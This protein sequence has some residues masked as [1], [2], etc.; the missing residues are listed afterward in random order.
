MKRKAVFLDGNNLFYRSFFAIRELTSSDGTPTNAIFGFLKTMIRIVNTEKPDYFAVCF[1]TKS[2]T[3]RS[4]I[5]PSYKANRP[6]TPDSLI[7]QTKLIREI[8]SRI[9]ISWFE[10][11]GY[12]A[13]DLLATFASKYSRGGNSVYVY[14]GDRDLLQVISDDIQVLSPVNRQREP[15]LFNSDEVYA[16]YGVYPHQI[17]D[18]KSLVGDTSDNIKG[19]PKIGPK[20]AAK[21]LQEYGSIEKILEDV[22]KTT[23]KAREFSDV[24]IRNQRIIKLDYDVQIQ[25]EYDSLAF[26][27]LDLNELLFVS[28]RYNLKSITRD[29]QENN[30]KKEAEMPNKENLSE[31]ESK[32][33]LWN[34]ENNEV[35]LSKIIASSEATIMLFKNTLAIVTADTVFRCELKD[36]NQPNWFLT[37]LKNIFSNEKIH[38]F[39][40][41]IKSILHYFSFKDTLLLKNSD[42]LQLAYFID[43]PNTKQYS[44]EN[45]CT[46][47]Q[48]NL[49]S[50]QE[51]CVSTCSKTLM[52]KLY[53]S[54]EIK[55][56]K[57]LEMPLLSVLYDMETAGVKI[58][59]DYLQNAEKE[60]KNRIAIVQENIYR[61]VG[62]EFNIASPK[63]LAFI[64][65]EKMHLPARKK[66]KTGYSTNV[67]VL[68]ELKPLSPVIEMVIEFRELSKMLNTYVVGL[69]KN[70]QKDDLIHT[71]Y[72]QAGPATGRISSVNP[73]LQNLPSDKVWG[74]Y[75]KKAFCIRND[76]NIFVSADYS[77]IDLRVLAHFSKDEKMCEAF[78]SDQD[79][80]DWTARKIFSI[81]KERQVIDSYRKI[82]KTVNFGVIYGMTPHGLSQ[83]LHIPMKEAKQF[84]DMY[85]RTFPGVKRFIERAVNDAKTTGYAITLLGRRRPIPELHSSNKNIV[86]LGERLAVNTVI[87]GTSADI[88]K[89]AMIDI[90]QSLFA[91]YDTKMILQIH[92]EIITE[93]P[94]EE[95]SEVKNIIEQKMIHAVPFS[96]PLKVS[97]HAG[98]TLAELK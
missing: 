11:N 75:I 12:E 69:Y 60:L 10:L 54:D 86:S 89:K 42:D 1:D 6:P 66:T 71:T 78:C 68:E 72:L 39:L 79:I 24:L 20:T 34:E 65:F 21:L 48:T 17:V 57:D 64:L 61:E 62:Q 87:Q 28:R 23:E 90:N 76:N 19:V 18:F 3:Y 2:K 59:K 50:S 27:E 41:D 13:D 45:F 58:S 94:E 92:D 74:N 9:N 35:I 77:Q 47:Y 43:K 8:L 5:L 97:F 52:D 16:K 46:E 70:I 88:I 98:I 96:V 83:S 40:F 81:P 37:S 38:K 25:F 36:I 49:Y 95:F 32:I 4:T 26:T 82:A 44:I 30:S 29:I 55:L 14:S 84:I 80:H 33:T 15:K 93:G 22:S 51:F 73:N 56:Y 85:F 67:S 63:Q 7:I 31:E 91:S 53:E